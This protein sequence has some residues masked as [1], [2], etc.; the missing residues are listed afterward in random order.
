MKYILFYSGLDIVNNE[1]FIAIEI[2]ERE[3]TKKKRRQFRGTF[4]RDRYY[5]D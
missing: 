3:N 1:L 4:E 2:I 5:I